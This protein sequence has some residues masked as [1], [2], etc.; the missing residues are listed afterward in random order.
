[1]LS[2]AKTP[3]KFL[4]VFATNVLFKIF[5]FGKVIYWL[6]WNIYITPAEFYETRFWNVLFLIVTV[7]P[8]LMTTQAV[9]FSVVRVV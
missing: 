7:F 5:I 8:P 9:P 3:A 6:L 1:M 2:V 4:A